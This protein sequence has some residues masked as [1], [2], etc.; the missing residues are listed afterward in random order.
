MSAS[1]GPRYKSFVVGE[2]EPEEANALLNANNQ[3]LRRC[4][5]QSMYHDLEN[6]DMFYRIG[7]LK[8]VILVRK[9]YKGLAMHNELSV[10]QETAVKYF[11]NRQL[12]V[13][14]TMMPQSLAQD[15]SN[16]HYV[17]VPLYKAPEYEI[18]IDIMQ[19]LPDQVNVNYNLRYVVVAVD[20]FSRF[21]WAHPVSDLQ[22]RHVQ[23]AFQLAMSRPD[24]P[25]LYY[26]HLRNEIEQ[27]TIDGGS[28]FKDV[29]PEVIAL[30]FPQA[31]LVT[32]NAKSKT[33]NRP[34]GNGPIEA[35]IRLLRRVIRD[36]TLGIHEDFLKNQNGSNQ[37]GLGQIL[38][39][40]NQQS[41][42]P[43]H[44]K[45]PQTL[46][47][48]LMAGNEGNNQVNE[49]WTYSDQQREK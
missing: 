18:Q 36:Y 30:V 37:Y 19:L 44:G 48:Q 40:Y 12:I 45:S 6:N 9:V 41:Q 49:T 47:R 21:M 14:M 13:Q 10:A 24:L 11:Y 33:G 20:S 29:F 7:Y 34:T 31:R 39:A 1:V 35:A 8:F 3:T 42:F 15:S 22:S 4:C 17:S 23:K 32:S 27:V 28:E 25:K 46:V 43:L 16:P 5:D 26:E 38:T 2:A